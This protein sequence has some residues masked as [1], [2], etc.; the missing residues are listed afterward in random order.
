[1]HVPPQK[2]PFCGH[3]T[4]R[5]VM[6]MKKGSQGLPRD[7]TPDVHQFR[8]IPESCFDLVNQY[9]TY[10]I[11]PTTNTENVFPLIGQG[12]P[13][14]WKELKIDKYDLEREE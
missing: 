3:T 11:Q 13:E 7:S 12:L 14:Q 2:V 5:E 8:G 6:R 9:G 4:D 10:E 1:M